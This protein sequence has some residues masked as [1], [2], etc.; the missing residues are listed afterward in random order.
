[1][2]QNTVVGALHQQQRLAET[3][4]LTHCGIT[5]PQTDDYAHWPDERTRLHR[6]CRTKRLADSRPTKKDYATG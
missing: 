6:P 3:E 4:P 1:M 2:D 5:R